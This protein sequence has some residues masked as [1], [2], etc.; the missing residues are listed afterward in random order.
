MPPIESFMGVDN[1]SCKRHFFNSL[2]KYDIVICVVSQVLES[3]LGLTLLCMDNGKARDID[4]F[5]IHAFCPAKE[6][7]RQL[8]QSPTEGFKVKDKVKGL[9]VNVNAETERV[10]VSLNERSLREDQEHIKLGHISEEDFPVH[11]SA[12]IPEKE[13]A[14]S[15][16]KHQSQRWAFQCVADGIKYFKAGKQT[17]ALQYLNKALQIDP[18]NVEALV[19]RGALYANNESY[20]RAIKDFENALAE[21]PSHQNARKYMF[22]TLMAQSKVH[23]DKEEFADAEQY[24]RQALTIQPESVEA[25]EALRFI[26]FRKVCVIF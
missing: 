22:E 5:G 20:H 4:E 16:R 26:F 13:C 18:T 8:Y 6:L 1:V 24:I 11:F 14:E 2:E 9:V 21:N 25:R 12:V 7:P 23:E 19:A 3:G 10:T 17:E 15:L